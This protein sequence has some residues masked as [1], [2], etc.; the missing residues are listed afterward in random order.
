MSGI[1]GAVHDTTA[2]SL[3]LAA[4]TQ[5]IDLAA[6]PAVGSAWDRPSTLPGFSVGGLAG[7]L[8]AGGTSVVARYLVAPAPDGEPVDPPQYFLTLLSADHD[9]ELNTG[10]R[11]RGEAVAAVGQEAMLATARRV[12]AEVAGRL[13]ALPAGTT[14]R[15]AGGLVLD[16]DDY[17]VTRLVELVVHTDDLAAS[18]GLATPA[19]DP[20]AVE[21]VIGCLLE[22]ARRRHGDLAVIRA[23]TRRERDTVSALRVL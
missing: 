3:L 20:A 21:L 14:V 1:V 4:A 23:L 2:R 6:E 18:V 5:A 13:A 15:V 17:C 12:L 8:V 22:M 9:D 16:L 10:I 11:Q 7:H 19:I